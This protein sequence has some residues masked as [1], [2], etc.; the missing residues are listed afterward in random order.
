MPKP[1]S[2][3]ANQDTPS[4]IIPR[5]FRVHIK[6]ASDIK[7]LFLRISQKVSI[8]FSKVVI[9]YD[10]TFPGLHKWYSMIFERYGWMLLA[11]DKSKGGKRT[12]RKG[13]GMDHKAD[14]QDK[15]KLYVHEIGHFIAACQEKI[16]STEE[17][18]RKIDLEVMVHN[19]ERLLGH[20]TK[21]FLESM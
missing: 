2:V 1:T 10:V 6:A 11:K 12:M 18:D 8:L 17:N 9:M 19:A 21:E 4:H 20:A 16:L 7:T 14:L 5:V 3:E 15:L 13:M